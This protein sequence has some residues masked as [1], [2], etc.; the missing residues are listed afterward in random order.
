MARM[1]VGPKIRTRRKARGQTQAALAEEVGISASYM[2]LIEQDKRQI[3][4]AL[5][6]RIAATL[7][8]PP[9]ELTGEAEQHVID[10]LE[11]LIADPVLRPLMLDATAASDLAGKHPLWARA[12]V[13]LYR[14]FLDRSQSVA[15]LSD[16][17]SQDPFL[18]DS[19]HA[20]LSHVTAI[21]STSEILD[22]ESGLSPEQAA[23]I[24]LMPT[25]NK[26]HG[27]PILCL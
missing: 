14:A 4:G 24:E 19:I 17:L 9:E 20:M 26:A 18:A 7:D 15:A 16:R 12:M 27:R 8:Y 5:L 6:N 22:Q 2:N 13:T 1:P 23:R 3:G 21:R 25:I 11:E 10:D